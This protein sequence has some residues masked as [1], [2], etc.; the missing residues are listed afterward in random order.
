MYIVKL[1][2]LVKFV[3]SYKFISNNLFQDNLLFLSK[4]Y[5]TNPNV[6]LL[7]QMIQ[8]RVNTAALLKK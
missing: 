2:Y 6:T 8:Q 5:F 4:I 1:P 3:L 7:F